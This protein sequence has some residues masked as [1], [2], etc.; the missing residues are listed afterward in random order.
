MT[1][2]L[3]GKKNFK[4]SCV[5]VW[6]DHDDLD[7]TS[8]RYRTSSVQLTETGDAAVLFTEPHC[9]G[10]AMFRSGRSDIT[11]LGDATEGGKRGFGPLKSIR[12]T[13]FR[14]R[15]KYHFMYDG[16]DLP[17]THSGLGGLLTLAK[18]IEDMHVV[19]QDIWRPY[20]IEFDRETEIGNYNSPKY[21]KLDNNPNEMRQLKDDPD[22]SFP[23]DRI[24]VVLVEDVGDGPGGLT[25][26]TGTGKLHE[27]LLA[28]ET[29]SSKLAFTVGRSIAHE[30][31]HIFGLGHGSNSDPTRLMTQAGQ[32][33]GRPEDAVSL[34][35][36][37]ADKVHTNLARV[38]STSTVSANPMLRRV[39]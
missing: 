38:L 10:E 13:P 5:G 22:F 3:Y 20:L 8:L 14:V 18:Q 7:D 29:R 27:P 16:D 37:D 31:G 1:I 32:L 36:A 11:D 24:H 21:F 28:V 4:G 39:A 2:K 23:A 15:I 34:S 25:G 33:T 6:L 12:L 26:F 19:L 17:G 35:P 9:R 30:I